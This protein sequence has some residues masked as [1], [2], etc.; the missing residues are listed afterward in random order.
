MSVTQSSSW[1]GKN[2]VF[3]VTIT[4][5]RHSFSHSVTPPDILVL[6]QALGQ[7]QHSG[8]H[9]AGPKPGAAASP[10]KLLKNAG[11]WVLPQI[12]WTRESGGRAFWGILMHIQVWEPL[13]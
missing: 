2:A 7:F 9:S 5:D 4:M 13:F 1:P 12:G 10:G 6:S 3:A 11:S 8:S